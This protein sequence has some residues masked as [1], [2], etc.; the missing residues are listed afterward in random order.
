MACSSETSSSR[1]QQ[2]HRRKTGGEH[3]IISEALHDLSQSLSTQNNS[4]YICLALWDNP[5]RLSPWTNLSTGR[6]NTRTTTVNLQLFTRIHSVTLS[7]RDVGRIGNVRRHFLLLHQT[8]HFHPYDPKDVR[9]RNK[10]QHNDNNASWIAT[11][12]FI[13]HEVAGASNS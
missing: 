3:H 13:N 9:H 2:H 12:P 5:Y 1:Q 8:I 11:P 6:M 4:A 10:H 7:C